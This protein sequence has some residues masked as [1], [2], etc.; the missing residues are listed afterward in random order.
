MDR[1]KKNQHPTP[2]PPPPEF[3]FSV[4]YTILFRNK[5]TKYL[6][7]SSTSFILFYSTFYRSFCAVDFVSMVATSKEHMADQRG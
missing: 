7:Y 3:I 1:K 5:L 4:Q 2:T 6:F